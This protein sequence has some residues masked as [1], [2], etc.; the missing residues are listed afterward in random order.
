MKEAYYFS[1]DANARNDEKIL[2]L[3]FKQGWEGYGLYWALIEK[4]R[5]ANNYKLKADYEPIAF[6]L[7]TQCERIQNVIESYNLFKI[8]EGYFW[9]ESLLNRM[10]LRELKSEKAR[11]SAKVRWNKTD[12]QTDICERNTNASKT[13]CED[14]AIKESKGKENKEIYTPKQFYELEKQK[15][16]GKYR[17]K[18]LHFIGYLFGKNEMKKP[19]TN[20]LKLEQQV[21]CEQ[22]SKLMKKIRDINNQKGEQKVKLLEMIMSMY[23]EPKY[24]RGKKSLY[25]T[26]NNWINRE[27]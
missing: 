5:E 6:E 9:S 4:L 3:I 1:H 7:R 23:N 10:K 18:Y 11:E 19:L 22:F 21:T 20:L 17:D 27:R 25:L 13:Q 2:R 12:I 16:E 15:A 8:K 26:L 14:D 24:T